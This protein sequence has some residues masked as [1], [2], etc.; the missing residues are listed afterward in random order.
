MVT[1]D[2]TWIRF[3]HEGEKI[4]VEVLDLK[5]TQYGKDYL[6]LKILGDDDEQ[7][8]LINI[9]PFQVEQVQVGHQYTLTCT[10]KERNFIQIEER[11]PK[12]TLDTVD[13][14]H[15]DWLVHDTIEEKKV[16]PQTTTPSRESIDVEGLVDLQN[17]LRY[18]YEE[19]KNNAEQ[20]KQ[21]LTLLEKVIQ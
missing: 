4:Q 13:G 17:F 21:L 19:S 11:K 10:N 8:K 18:K 14:E 6:V 16:I 1:Y 20:Y 3:D 9:A 5:K 2:S 15:P 7:A 12:F